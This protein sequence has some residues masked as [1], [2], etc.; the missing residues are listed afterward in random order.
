MN[1][2]LKNRIKAA[3]EHSRTTRYAI[4]SLRSQKSHRARWINQY[5]A[6]YQW[7]SRLVGTDEEGFAVESMSRAN[8]MI[9]RCTKEIADFDA[10]ILS[11][12][13]Y[14]ESL[15]AKENAQAPDSFVPSADPEVVAAETE[16]YAQPVAPTHEHV[17]LPNGVA[18]CCACCDDLRAGKDCDCNTAQDAMEAYEAGGAR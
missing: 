10:Q 2:E 3:T 16:F 8:E 5:T 1:K 9:A 12:V 18:D 7:N 13:K 4:S 14:A 11:A 15:M 6:T 17:L